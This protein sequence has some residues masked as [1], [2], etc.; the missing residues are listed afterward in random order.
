MV[1]AEF[2]L[3]VWVGFT[4]I[5]LT[6]SLRASLP[7]P[8]VA[9]SPTVIYRERLAMPKRSYQ[10]QAVVEVDREP[11]V[12]ASDPEPTAPVSVPEPA[13]DVANSEPAAVSEPGLAAVTPDPEPAAVIADVVCR[14]STPD[15]GKGVAGL[16]VHTFCPQLK[17]PYNKYVQRNV[18]EEAMQTKSATL[19][20]IGELP[21]KQAENWMD[22]LVVDEDDT[23]P[24]IG[25][26]DLMLGS[27]AASKCCYVTNVC[28]HSRARRNGIA[29]KL[30]IAAEA[31]VS[32]VLGGEELVLHVGKTNEAAIRLYEGLGF[33]PLVDEAKIAFYSTSQF[34]DAESPPELLLYK[35]VG[36]PRPGSSAG[37]GRSA[38]SALVMSAARTW[39][40]AER[41]PATTAEAATAGVAHAELSA[42]IAR[43]SMDR[44]NAPAIFARGMPQI[45]ALIEAAGRRRDHD[46]QSMDRQL[47]AP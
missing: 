14:A 40:S 47:G 42:A 7:P 11:A 30:M 45:S 41:E 15:E 39:A 29:R 12:F 35:P 1:V 46:K 16:R 23:G 36:P 24:V 8:P 26:A 20:A 33:I 31:H 2:V 37:S 4:G 34:V 28:V 38:A 25:C 10:E 18:Y 43:T 9:G 27:Q 6:P 5:S 17:S 32:E 13:V 21:H 19:V 44:A 22:L 3:G